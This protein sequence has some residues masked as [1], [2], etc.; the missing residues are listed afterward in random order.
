MGKRMHKAWPLLLTS[1]A[2][3]SC[4]EKGPAEMQWEI[5]FTCASDAA[6]TAAIQLRVYADL[7]QGEDVV[8]ET[9][10]LRGKTA[11]TEVLS[12]GTYYFEAV[13]TD[14][15]S[16]V[17]AGDCHAFDLPSQQVRFSIT[18]LE[19]VLAMPMDGGPSSPDDDAG[20]WFPGEF[21]GGA[22]GDDGGATCT[23]SEC[24]GACSLPKGS[25]R[26]AEFEGHTYLFCPET[27][28]W[29]DARARCRAQ[30]ADLVVIESAAENSFLRSS[31]GANRWLGAND[32]GFNGSPLGKCPG[33]C[34]KTGDEGTWK[35]VSGPANSERGAALC[36]VSKNS[37]DCNGS[38]YS[39]WAGQEPNNATD[40]GVPCIPY[41][42]CA[43]GEDCALMAS[44]G[45]WQDVSCDLQKPFICESY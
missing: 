13:A 6:R 4:S 17:I 24:P 10:L 3:A 23:G 40:M 26:C 19:C 35:W 31:G 15:R 32:R 21:D 2:L 33:E 42:S 9:N 29:T 1:L 11:P 25:C 16:E 5:A 44:D 27:F 22:S 43:V 14:D 12:P 39:N 8:Y 30:G 45:T 7:C 41:V 38:A 20:A 36:E 28:S 34:N 18:S 37:S